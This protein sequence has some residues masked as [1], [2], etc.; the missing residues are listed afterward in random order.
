MKNGGNELTALYHSSS[1]GEDIVMYVLDL[2]RVSRLNGLFV[3]KGS[4]TFIGTTVGM[5]AST[6]VANTWSAF[7][8]TMSV[9]GCRDREISLRLLLQRV[10]SLR[11][12]LMI[13]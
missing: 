3:A 9:I 11:E 6:T 7:V 1:R 8:M 12:V 2:D 10:V 13:D 4:C 5:S